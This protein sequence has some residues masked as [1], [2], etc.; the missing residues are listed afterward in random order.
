MVGA[1]GPAVVRRNVDAEGDV[2]QAR[3]RVAE[4][5]QGPGGGEGRPTT[6]VRG[7]TPTSSPSASCILAGSGRSV[8]DGLLGRY[9]IFHDPR[10]RER[11][12]KRRDTVTVVDLH[13]HI[14]PGVDDGARE[15][16]ESVAIARELVRDGVRVAAA[17]P[18]VRDDYPTDAATMERL[19]DEVRAALAAQSVP[20]DLRGGGEVALG[21][22]QTLS[23]DEL[24]RFRLG[25]SPHHL[26]VECPYLG[27]PLD[28]EQTLFEL[29]LKGLTPVLAHPERNDEVQHSPE[30]LRRL[31]DSGVL[32]QVTAGSIDGRLGRSISRTALRLLEMGAVHVLASDGHS[33]DLRAVGM[34]DACRALNNDALAKWL[35]CDVPMAILAGE[36]PP[37]R[38]GGVGPRGRRPFWRIP[39]RQE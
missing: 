39:R 27:W 4:L 17:T 22:V 10:E 2:H 23:E 3:N 28:I 33:A 31:V 26:L 11:A 37:P 20:L 12:S 7:A 9:D 8:H 15:L 29:R 13:L 32:V 14:L 1:L 36:D 18:H 6:S 24:A 16:N 19:V 25:G 34:T 30:L 38:P 35:T 5:G 21:W